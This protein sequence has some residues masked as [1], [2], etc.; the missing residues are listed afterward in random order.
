MQV[1]IEF[2]FHPAAWFPPCLID[3]IAF[4]DLNSAL[5][6]PLDAEVE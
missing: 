1:L 2:V 3:R 5:G 6:I 4:V